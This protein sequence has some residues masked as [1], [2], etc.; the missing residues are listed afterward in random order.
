LI[1][2]LYID[3]EKD[4]LEICKYYLEKSEDLHVAIALSAAEAFKLI[5]EHNFDAII[6]D[7]QMPRMD[8]IEFLKSL[9]SMGNDMPFILFTGRGR[10]EVVIEALNSGADF[11]LQKGGNP[12]AQFHELE[13]KVREAVRRSRAERDLHRLNKELLAIKEC[14]KAMIRART[15]QELLD[16]ICRIV[17][18]I[19]GYKLAWIGMGQDD[20]AKSILP[21]AWS[22]LYDEYVKN[23]HASWGDNE[24]GRGVTGSAI[25]S[26][27]TVF[28][29]DF[30]SDE[31][32]LPWRDTALK[33]GF[34][35]SI[36]IPLKGENKTF[37]SLTLYSD[38]TNGFSADETS[39]LEE[40]AG[41]LAFGIISLRTTKERAEAEK[42][43]LVSEEKLNSLFKNM[44]N[45]F[46][47]CQ[48][49]F[50]DQ[51]RP[52][53]FIYLDVN[54]AFTKL[55]GLENVIGRRVTDIIP[56]V[57][58]MTP[59][60][61]E[62]YGRVSMTGMSETL[63]INFTPLNIWLH[64]SVYSPEK[65]FFVAIF[66]N[67]TQQKRME[68]ERE[69]MIE[70][71]KIINEERTLKNL[72]HATASFFQKKSGCEA[73]GI[74]LQQGDDFPYYECHGFPDDFIRTENTLCARDE[75]GTIIRD[76]SGNPIIE[77]MCGNVI[78]GRFD[79]AKPFF[80]SHGSF[81]SNCTTELLAN[82]TDE[83]RQARTRNRCNG[84]GYESVALVPLKVGDRILGLLQFNDRRKGMF[85]LD[86]L[87]QWE[88]MAGYLGM[89]VSEI[90]A[91]DKLREDEARYRSLI[92][93]NSDAIVL[94]QPDGCIM[95]A[96]SAACC[97][98]KMTEEEII[99]TGWRGI[100]PSDGV[101][102][103]LDKNCMLYG[104][105]NE[106]DFLRKDGT[107]FIGEVVADEFLDLEGRLQ[108]VVTIRDITERKKAEQDLATSQ[109]LLS[110]ILNTSPNLV[111]LYDLKEHCNIFANREVVEF[112][113][114]SP[115]QLVEMG[116]HLFER[117]LHP[118]DVEN[119]MRYQDEIRVLQDGEVIEAEYRMRRADGTWCW[120]RS[121][122]TVFDR[123]ADG[124]VRN[125]LGVAEDVTRNK[126]ALEALRQSEEKFR[127]ITEGSP[128]SIII[129]NNDL[130][131][132]WAL[133]PQLGMTLADMI[134]K[135]DYEIL[136]KED[137]DML[138]SMKKEVLENAKSI[139]FNLCLTSPR[140]G[141][142]Y[143]DGT[144]SPRYD[145]NGHILGIIGYFRNITEMV[146]TQEALG[147][148]NRK[149]NL[150][151][152]ISRHDMQNKLSV[153]NGYL[154]IL[155]EQADQPSLKPLFDN[156]GRTI[157]QL[158][159]LIKFTK[160]YENVGIKAPQ[161]QD[162]HELVETAKG[163]VNL[164]RITLVNDV[165]EGK[166]MLADPMV[167][168][169]FSN[170]IENVVRHGD[171][172]TRI[173]F[174]LEEHVDGVAVLCEDDG[175]GISPK[176]R[177]ELFKRVMMSDHGLGLFLSQEILSITDINITEEGIP[178]QGAKFVITV[179]ATRYRDKEPEV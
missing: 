104:A 78:C 47:Y 145:S 21:V 12:K 25:R 11:Y 36:S 38:K 89:A 52:L 154:E 174:R 61:F 71:L 48:M 91:R 171:R 76:F 4:L 70:F 138:T 53:D 115:E 118:D 103:F 106:L 44:L 102:F 143:F 29:H 130:R 159:A 179:P 55:T 20:D 90:I 94:I 83:D 124:S 28:I 96:N 156:I 64:I 137:A 39:L 153:L 146:H 116:P 9:R 128:D 1:D 88:R 162:I 109:Q 66:E 42:A 6:S 65:G 3:D 169:V 85:S 82:T 136:Q 14:N 33:L 81:W 176:V 13:Y 69:L 27:S 92:H 67:V 31:R 49:V 8:G 16:D 161:W 160:N 101:D 163:K 125:E 74:R 119:V 113:G 157:G 132:T 17:G 131:Y 114:Y 111:Y 178:G 63:D 19:A 26:G 7:Y 93:N 107:L 5:E 86:A 79:P 98:F 126:E 2:I 72:I 112:L 99:S 151:S 168:N 80:T 43:K 30:T 56:G 127:L 95:A 40:M 177:E 155:S 51:G 129:Q 105:R 117:I 35:S 173:V 108:I 37:G 100:S 73:V 167:N 133:N 134:G 148:A 175:I 32:M 121:R 62:I 147:E 50:D 87:R 172:A 139:K 10:E 164:D 142:E 60:L 68:I 141:R 122:D 150:L 77:C 58:E 41:D 84:E 166:E 23:I 165:P 34:H 140:G 135:T 144:Y 15:E 45:G 46:A 57:K 22:G 158:N 110:K 59:E 152:S 24:R 170:L 18:D 149:L 120:L 123:D 97:A 54:A 75:K